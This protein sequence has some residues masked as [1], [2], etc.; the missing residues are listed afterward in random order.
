[1]RDTK[2]IF[3]G[4]LLALAGVV[5]LETAHAAPLAQIKGGA[6]KQAFPP[7]GEPDTLRVSAFELE[8]DLVTNADYLR[9]VK[10]HPQW[11]RD[12]V[13]GL[14]ADERYLSHWQGPETLGNSPQI[15][16]LQPVTYV[17]WFGARA[18][19]KSLGLRLPRIAEWEFAAL[20]SETSQNGSQDAKWKENLV[21]WYSRAAWNPLPQIGTQAPANIYGLRDMHVLVWEWVD[22]FQS[23]LMSTENRGSGSQD[24]SQFCAGGSINAKD[25]ENY[26]AFMRMAFRSSLQGTFSLHNLGFRCAK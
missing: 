6:W 26:P 21:A 12:R 2:S 11:R 13:S 7:K 20:A 16:A 4:F 22:D 8:K 25:V 18:Y 19:C 23:V 9:F 3:A 1:V 14:L 24:R 10:A 17:S 5:A 15:H